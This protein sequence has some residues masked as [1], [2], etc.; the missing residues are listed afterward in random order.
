MTQ[1]C[2]VNWYSR[3]AFV[4]L[5]CFGGDLSEYLESDSVSPGIDT[6]STKLAEQSNYIIPFGRSFSECPSCLAVSTTLPRAPVALTISARTN[7]WEYD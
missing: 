7:L 5:I 2:P 1:R 6:V 3:P 4:Q